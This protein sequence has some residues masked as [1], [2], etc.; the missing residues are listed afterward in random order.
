MKPEIK[1]GIITILACV[2]FLVAFFYLKDIKLQEMYS[3]MIQFQNVKGLEEGQKAYL[4]GV[5]V[6]TVKKIRVVSD[7]VFITLEIDRKFQLP[8]E[9]RFIVDTMG[10]MGERYVGISRPEFYTLRV[11]SEHANLR[12]HFKKGQEIRVKSYEVNNQPA[13]AVNIFGKIKQVDKS[14]AVI[15]LQS[16]I[17]EL[18][19]S[20]I[21]LTSLVDTNEEFKCRITVPPSFIAV[22]SEAGEE[23]I[24]G[25]T[26][27]LEYNG[28]TSDCEIARPVLKEQ[29]GYEFLG[30]NFFV[31]ISYFM[32]LRN[33]TGGFH[34]MDK[35]DGIFDGK[36]VRILGKLYMGDE[37][38]STSDLL[39][40]GMDLISVLKGTI[41]KVDVVLDDSSTLVRELQKFTDKD[42]MD[43]LHEGL[44]NVVVT[45]ENLK[46][47]SAN[48]NIVSNNLK[49]S[50]YDIKSITSMVSGKTSKLFETIQNFFRNT[51]KLVIKQ[52]KKGGDVLQ[53]MDIFTTDLKN[54]LKRNRIPVT[55]TL[56]N[57]EL[58]TEYFR[59]LFESIYDSGKT[60]KD[61]RDMFRNLSVSG[62][63]LRDV[64]DDIQSFFSDGD[65][66]GEIKRGQWSGT[67]RK[68]KKAVE[69]V[70]DTTGSFHYRIFHQNDRNYYYSDAFLKV[71]PGGLQNFL[72]LGANDI[73]QSSKLNLEIGREAKRYRLSGGII[74]SQP[75]LGFDYKFGAFETG[76]DLVGLE[77]TMVKIHG[78][79]VFAKDIGVLLEVDDALDSARLFNVGL[80]KK[81]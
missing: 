57:L 67:L 44:T 52:L 75:G 31:S 5:N 66:K 71:F 23:F 54:L 58:G 26:G 53:N 17:P 63:K 81:F 12:A 3:V 68:A 30:K 27:K 42:I 77:D 37:L 50:S 64:L 1:V 4:H 9:P 29:Q 65:N 33:S 39:N 69:T 6:G 48:F 22:Q 49:S 11:I 14:G 36:K 19:N 38:P 7:R 51:E 18:E 70:V 32:V 20:F 10:L 41:S 15:E 60:S 24:Q 62:K 2:L 76:F 73:G 61:I 35:P 8:E 34:Q 56:E 79:I 21:T 43:K 78:A 28:K 40:E 80:E 47:A 59:N 45:S 74:D 55:H 25:K 16:H 46:S 13:A 72:Q